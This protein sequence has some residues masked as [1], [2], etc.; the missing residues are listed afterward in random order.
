[1]LECVWVNSTDSYNHISTLCDLEEAGEEEHWNELIT[2]ALGE[3]DMEVITVLKFA[4]VN[5]SVLSS[6]Q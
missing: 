1:M 5:I 4:K 6:T 3:T 2:A